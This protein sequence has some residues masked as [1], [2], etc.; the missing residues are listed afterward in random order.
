MPNDKD[1]LAKKVDLASKQDTLIAGTNIT[2]GQDGRTISATGGGSSV[3]VTP[4]L[5]TGTRIGSITVDSTVSNLY[6]PNPTAVSVSQVV[7]SGTEI[8]RVSVNGTS[9]SIYTPSS[10]VA[11]LSDLTDVQLSSLS[12]RDT[13]IYDATSSKWINSAGG[14]GGGGTSITKL[15]DVGFTPSPGV[16]LEYDFGEDLEAYDAIVILFVVSGWEGNNSDSVTVY[17]K[18]QHL[19]TT[20][21]YHY[22]KGTDYGI[23]FW[24]VSGTT[25]GL[26]SIDGN[27][28]PQYKAVY[29][30][31]Y[32]SGGGGGSSV[33]PNPQD[34]ATDTLTKIEID[35]TVY[36]I[37]GGGGSGSFDGLDWDNAETLTLPDTTGYTY[38]PPCEGVIMVTTYGEVGGMTV[39][40]TGYNDIFLTCLNDTWTTEWVPV[41]TTEYT[42]KKLSTIYEY[43]QDSWAKFIPWKTS[44]G[45]SGSGYSETNLYTASSTS[46]VDIPLTWSLTDYD[47]YLFFC[48]DVN[49]Q[50]GNPWFITQGVLTD[51]IGTQNTLTFYPFDNAGVHYY[52]TTTQLTAHWNSQ[53]FYIRQIVGLNFGSGGGSNTHNYSTS[54]QVVGTWIDGSTIYE[55]TYTIPNLSSNYSQVDLGL[56]TS[57]INLIWIHE[58]FGFNAPYG[59]GNVMP[60][61]DSSAAGEM[62]IIGYIVKNNN[63][64]EYHYR[65]GSYIENG[66]A[67]ITFRYTKN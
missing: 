1:L 33:I 34:P 25:Y 8:A 54:E 26:G 27:Y 30:I 66:T 50:T 14:G 60:Y 63:T 42:L 11:A 45:G 16:W 37:A 48:N 46:F 5:T 55:K 29:G 19:N 61:S 12:D 22:I 36:D 64:V 20:N 56:L 32:G 40:R 15:W 53:G 10:V 13:L 43:P 24:R 47:A 2:I 44:G 62:G 17:P 21:Y 7:S 41:T 6:A 67:Y 59:T 3:S 4:I 23:Q 49:T 51:L 35:G 31:K 18:I 9:T 39:R 38:T 28:P 57:S 52:V 65:A 58:G